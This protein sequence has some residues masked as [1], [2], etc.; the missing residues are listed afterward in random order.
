MTSYRFPDIDK[1]IS[2]ITSKRNLLK[3]KEQ[4]NL[5][6]KNDPNI[7]VGSVFDNSAFNK[8]LNTVFSDIQQRQNLDKKIEQLKAESRIPNPNKMNVNQFTSGL[9]IDLFDTYNQIIKIKNPS[10]SDIN[11]ILDKNY[12]KL[13]IL[14][15]LFT[16]FSIIYYILSIK[17]YL[18]SARRKI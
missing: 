5:N 13:S 15:I 7:T 8:K 18:F 3:N 11:K 14:I 16:I 9:Y 12:R 4:N 10:V 2:N 17:S 1:D 6:L